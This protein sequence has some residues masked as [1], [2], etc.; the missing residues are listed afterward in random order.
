MKINQHRIDL[1]VRM[2]SI[3]KCQLRLDRNLPNKWTR[4]PKPVEKG[5]TTVF[6]F[7]FDTRGLY[8][9]ENCNTKVTVVS[10][11]SMLDVKISS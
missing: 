3:V 10:F 4:P 1:T 9:S 6:K 8:N 11:K 5:F 7:Y 2:N